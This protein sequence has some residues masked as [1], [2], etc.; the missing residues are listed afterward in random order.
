MKDVEKLE[1]QLKGLA[2]GAPG[3]Y[4][5]ERR[6]AAARADQRRIKAMLEGAKAD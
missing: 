5:L 2:P 4:E 1:E 3:R 6:L